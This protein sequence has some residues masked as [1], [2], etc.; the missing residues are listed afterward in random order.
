MPTNTQQEIVN[1]SDLPKYIQSKIPYSLRT[2]KDEYNV[3]DLPSTIQV[4]IQDYLKKDKFIQ[5]AKAFDIIPNISEYGDFAVL[6]TVEITILEYIKN[7]FMTLPKDYPFEP[8]FGSTL[9]LHLHAKDTG[10]RK[11]LISNEVDGIIEAISS[12]FGA[13]IEVQAVN[14]EDVEYG[15]RSEYTVNISL[16]I[17]DKESTIEFNSQ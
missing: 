5:Y 4:L 3:E 17:N 2:Y 12:D 10:L 8:T 11:T 1:I 14:I 6:D 13:K 9:K 16:K 7:Y 15:D